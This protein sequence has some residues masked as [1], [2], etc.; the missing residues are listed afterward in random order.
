[1]IRSRI[2]LISAATAFLARC[3]ATLVAGPEL[4]V[5]RAIAHAARH[6]RERGGLW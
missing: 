1:M 6:A 4:R 3:L 2:N 5:S